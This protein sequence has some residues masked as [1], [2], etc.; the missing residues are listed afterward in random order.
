[1]VS[2]AGVDDDTRL[3]SRSTPRGNMRKNRHC[4]RDIRYDSSALVQRRERIAISILEKM[5]GSWIQDLSMS[6]S[7]RKRCYASFT[8]VHISLKRV[9]LKAIQGNVSTTL[10]RVPGDSPLIKLGIPSELN[11]VRHSE[12]KS[13]TSRDM[14][15]LFQKTSSSDEVDNRNADNL[16]SSS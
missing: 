5:K 11:L 14:A 16:F 8:R 2:P 9:I 1:M 12:F 13:L 15:Q 4:P 3:T 7:S 10:I 6:K